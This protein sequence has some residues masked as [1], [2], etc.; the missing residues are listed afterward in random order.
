VFM[1]DGFDITFGEMEPEKKHSMSHRA[2]AFAL[3]VD[4]CFASRSGT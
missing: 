3:L 4:A 2:R 1:P